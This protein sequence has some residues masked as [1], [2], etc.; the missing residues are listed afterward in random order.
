MLGAKTTCKDRWRQVLAEANKIK[1]KHLITL[2]PAISEDQTT[3][4]KDKNLQ[5]IVPQSLH[6]TFT[7]NQQKWLI[8][9][10]D[11]VQ[12]IKKIQHVY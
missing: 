9:F 2:Q 11:F 7:K 10:S 1:R 6:P 12:E 4:M 3:E 5:L 8:T